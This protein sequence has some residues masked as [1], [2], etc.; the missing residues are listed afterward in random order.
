MI[1]AAKPLSNT[2]AWF[3]KLETNSLRL[4]Q[5]FLCTQNNQ[6]QFQNREAKSVCWDKGDIQYNDD[7]LLVITYKRELCDL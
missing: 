3:I 7:A 1:F 4:G 6:E 5:N 2:E